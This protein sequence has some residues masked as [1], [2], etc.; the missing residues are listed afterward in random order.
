MKIEKKI[1]MVW[2][3]IFLVKGSVH[4][5]TMHLVTE[6]YPPFNMSFE[7]GDQRNYKNK[8][9]GISTEIVMELFKRAKINYTIELLP[10][11]R[12]YSMALET[13]NYG[14]FST[15]RTATREKLFKWVGPLV[16]NNWVLLAKKDRNIHVDTLNEA[17][18]YKIGGYLEDAVAL[19]LMSQSFKLDLTTRDNLN[20]RKID[21][22]RIDLWAT[23]HRLGYY[24][25]KQEGVVGLETVF[26]FK[27][28]IMSIAFNKSVQTGTVNRL[29]EIIQQMQ[30]DGTI[31]EINRRYE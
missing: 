31:E 7:K 26:T 13:P 25:A 9:I 16:K 20:A 14:V 28:T 8:I 24:L 17:R 30:G 5:E 22:D 18:K 15:T 27:K 6:N 2:I 19:Y 23:G 3:I 4:A 21:A 10:W 29:N 11:K 12:A 1:F